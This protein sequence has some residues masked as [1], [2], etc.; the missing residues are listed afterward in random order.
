M[1]FF[2]LFL[3]LLSGAL[4]RHLS[5]FSLQLIM[6]LNNTLSRLFFC[7]DVCYCFF[8]LYL[9]NMAGYFVIFFF[10]DIYTCDSFYILLSC[11]IYI[12]L[13]RGRL[14]SH[15]GLVFVDFTI[16]SLK[17]IEFSNNLLCISYLKYMSFSFFSLI[18]G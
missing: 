8:T 16:V 2:T 5:Y 11:F 10:S 18:Y 1:H 17:Y 13:E 7:E 12:Q 6:L 3:I 9:C 4:Y 14:N 15:Y